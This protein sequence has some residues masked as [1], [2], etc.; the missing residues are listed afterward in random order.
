[1]TEFVFFL[2]EPSAAAMLRGLVPRLFSG[3]HVQHPSDD[4]RQYLV[5]ADGE[6]IAMVRY[7]VFEGKQDLERQLEWKLRGYRTP[8]ARFV[9]LRDQDSEDCHEVKKRLLGMCRQA[10]RADSLVRIACC[11]LESWYLA[12]LLAVER[13]LNLSGISTR[14]GRAKYRDP[15]RLVNAKEELRRLTK[16]RYQPVSG[17][18]EIGPHLDI[19]NLRSCSFGVLVRGL[20][21]LIHGR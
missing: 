16:N 10:G 6:L 14:Q 21:K 2:E 11:E 7:I 9:V 19:D 15:D 12:D 13:A 1:M 4:Q 3:A 5:A 20:R 18:R 8:G 17:S